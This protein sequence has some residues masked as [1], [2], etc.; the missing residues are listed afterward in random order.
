MNIV[1]VIKNFFSAVAIALKLWN[2]ELLRKDGERRQ[3]EKDL[4]EQAKRIKNGR[5]A[6]D[7]AR[8]SGVPD[9]GFRD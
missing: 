1:L 8:T 9:D 6:A 5:D 3:K 2:D 7:R 4:D